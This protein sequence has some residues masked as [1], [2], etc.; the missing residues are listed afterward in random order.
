MGLAGASNSAVTGLQAQSTY[1]AMASDNIA[2]ASTIGYK[3]VKGVFST[4]ITTK[5]S[6]SPATG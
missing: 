5:I 2:N 1:I 6:Y 4:L 3:S